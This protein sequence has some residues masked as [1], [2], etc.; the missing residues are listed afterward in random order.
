LGYT[1]IRKLVI[2]SSS[3]VF[4]PGEANLKKKYWGFVVFFLGRS[5]NALLSAPNNALMLATG[6]I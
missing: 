1:S 3:I 5:Q 2:G 4:F 6:I